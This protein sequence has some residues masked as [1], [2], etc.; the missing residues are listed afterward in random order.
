MYKGWVFIFVTASLVF[1]LTNRALGKQEQLNKTFRRSEERYHSLFEN[2]LEGFAHCKML[3]DDRGRPL[4]FVYLDVNS[5]FVRL[6]GLKHAIGRKVTEVFPGVKELHPEVFEIYG[7]VA[8]TGR[9]EKFEIEFKPAGT[10]FSISVYSTE[11]EYFVAVFD[12]ITPRKRAEEELLKSET[13]YRELVQNANSIILRRNPEGNVTFFNEF[14]QSFFGYTEDEIIGRNIVGA[15]VPETESTGR[16]LAFIIRDIGE[17]PE[18]Y[19]TNENENILKNGERV[20]VAWT[21]KAIR[22]ENGNI[23]EIL[24]IG[25]DITARKRAEEE[26]DKLQVQLLQGQK[27]QAIGQLAGG[28]AHDFNNI[29][30]AIIS[31]GNLLL[32][33][34]GKNDPLRTY[35]DKMLRSSEKAAN[36]VSRLLAYSRKQIIYP[37]P[38]DVNRIVNGLETLLIRL[39]GEDIELETSLADKDLIVT[40]DATQMEQVLMNLVTNGRDSMPHGGT[41]TIGTELAEIDDEFIKVHGYGEAGRYARIAVSDTGAGIDEQTKERL[42]E[43][44]FTTKEVGKGTGLGLAMAYGIIKQH[45]GFIKVHSE[46]GMGTT[47]EIYLPLISCKAEENKPGTD[48]VTHG[49]TETILIA[50]DNTEVRAVANEILTGA[51]YKV[52]EA[53]DGDDAIHKFVQN[54]ETIHLAILD[55]IMP[56]KNGKEVYDSIKQVRPDVRVIFTSGYTADI[57]QKKGITEEG[58]DIILK[59]FSTKSF[60]GEIRSM[61]DKEN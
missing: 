23:V 15:I 34:I 38:V 6:T 48:C 50:E 20:W 41:L 22:D 24:G 44:F 28:I 30:T 27:I 14:A 61:L 16:D 12:D 37:K 1:Y 35:V 45:N 36:L 59:P 3:Y 29:L 33:K 32:M 43:P 8:L 10:W 25:N 57:I 40:A 58:L 47:A 54:Q 52:I 13:K 56:K 60:L 2:M 5:A 46:S 31:Y 21:N 49:G 11:K 9:P 42:F 26:K 18:K 51:G 17:H 55:V 39:I 53:V 19:T 7:R 4:D